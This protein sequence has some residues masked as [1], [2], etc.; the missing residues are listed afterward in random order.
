MQK[1]QNFVKLWQ[2]VDTL[3]YHLYPSLTITSQDITFYNLLIDKLLGLKVQSQTK[4]NENK[5]CC[6][7]SARF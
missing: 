1:E 6:R 7:I 2:N 5:K 3:K 4:R